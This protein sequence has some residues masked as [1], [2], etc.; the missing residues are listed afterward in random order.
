MIV[1]ARPPL[2]EEIAAAFPIVLTHKGIIYAWGDRIY[3]P[4][5]ISIPP[6]GE[7][8]VGKVTR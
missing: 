3:N 7:E 6:V 8:F 1:K 2:F 5:A 4:D